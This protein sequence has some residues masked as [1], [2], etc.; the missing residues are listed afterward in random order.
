MKK[1]D[2][3]FTGYSVTEAAKWAGTLSCGPPRP[4]PG[5]FRV[6]YN[7]LCTQG[8]HSYTLTAYM[9]PAKSHNKCLCAA[10]NSVCSAP[11]WGMLKLTRWQGAMMRR[12]WGRDEG[13][14]RAPW[15]F[16]VGVRVTCGRGRWSFASIWAGG[17]FYVNPVLVSGLNVVWFVELI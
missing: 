1:V 11:W 3:I 4:E 2:N 8:A 16:R 14:M 13:S 7:C 17:I 10:A 6:A 5:H 15:G 9:R 12:R